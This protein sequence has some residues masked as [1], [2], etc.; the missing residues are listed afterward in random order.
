MLGMDSG[1]TEMYRNLSILIYLNNVISKVFAN[2]TACY[3]R[4]SL[5]ISELSALLLWAYKL[6][7]IKLQIFKK[8]LSKK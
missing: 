4:M 5:L 7:G 1:L 3:F 6:I 2:Q 8:F